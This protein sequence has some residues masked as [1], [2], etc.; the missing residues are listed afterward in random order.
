MCIRDRAI[1]AAGLSNFYHHRTAPS[2]RA[3]DLIP[4]PLRGLELYDR[5]ELQ[6]SFVH[7]ES[8]HVRD[9]ALM[10]EGIVCAACVWLNERHVSRLPGVLEFRVNY[11]TH[12]ALSL[13]HI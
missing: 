11:S 7:V 9:A 6:K 1:V 2:R 3:E 5:P 12:R 8:E 4:E 10:M 13:I